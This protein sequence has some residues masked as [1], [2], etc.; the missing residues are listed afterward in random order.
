MAT[1]TRSIQIPPVEPAAWR[2]ST[3]ARAA[4]ESG[5]V[6]RDGVRVHWQ[7]FGDGDPT[8]LLLPTFTI[9]DWRTW[10]MQVA[11]LARHFRVLTFD[12]RGNGR[13]DRPEAGSAY[14]PQEVAA[15]AIAVMDAT[16]TDRAITVSVSAGTMWNLVL[17]ATQPE[18]IARAVFIGPLFGAAEPMPGW[19]LA[20]FH[21]DAGGYQGDARYN[22][23]FIERDYAAFLEWWA[24]KAIP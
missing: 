1:D 23:N 9:V 16:G 13:S 24:R 21:A 8:L 3:R 6:E 11:Y 10:R 7:R 15:D 18:R 19:A 5:Y 4:D 17:C 20:D 22:R 2:D 14:A 12:P